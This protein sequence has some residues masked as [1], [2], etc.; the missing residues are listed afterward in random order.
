[1]GIDRMYTTEQA[2]ELLREMGIQAAQNTMEQWRVRGRGPCYVKVMGKIYYHE[3]V[4]VAF[5]AGQPVIT[6]PFIHNRIGMM[7]ATR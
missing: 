3:S 2:V 7:E 1:M 6:A 4:L 5:S